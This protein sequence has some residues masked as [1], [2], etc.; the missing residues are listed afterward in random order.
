MR[1]SRTADLLCEMGRFGQKTG[2]GWYDYA[3]G[4]RDAI[5]SPAVERLIE[6][7]RKALGIAPRRISDQEIV[8]RLVYSLVNEGARIVD[9]GIAARAG[10]VDLVYLA[11]YGFPLHLGGPMHYA[12]EQGLYNVVRSMR[13]FA[14]NPHDD[15]AFWQ[16]APLLEK[17]AAEGGSLGRPGAA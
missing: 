4:R 11:G 7:H 2:A 15:A 5:P 6:D 3:P 9:E 8:Q 17:L 16:P 12:E 1:Y 14:G 13:R 10:D